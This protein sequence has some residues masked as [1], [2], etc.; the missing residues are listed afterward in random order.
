LVSL[1]DN[2]A[3]N[4][5]FMYEKFSLEQA[6]GLTGYTGTLPIEQ[7][8]HSGEVVIPASLGQMFRELQERRIAFFENPDADTEDLQ[9]YEDDTEYNEASGIVKDLQQRI[10][11]M[12]RRLRMPL[13]DGIF[14]NIESGG[15]EQ[16][17]E[18]MSKSLQRIYLEHVYNAMDHSEDDIVAW[19]DACAP[20]KS[21]NGIVVGVQD[22]G[23]GPDVELLANE[24]REVETR[25]GQLTFDAL[26]EYIEQRHLRSLCGED[27]I[28]HGVKGFQRGSGN[29][30]MLASPS[31]RCSHIVEPGGGCTAVAVH[32][33]NEFRPHVAA[34]VNPI[35]QAGTWQDCYR[36][37]FKG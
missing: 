20:D 31:V 21:T 34:G 35:Q 30:A 7:G 27:H 14:Y 32:S 19:F 6:Y 15:Y 25:A 28:G 4:Y 37:M 16:L 18:T 23:P 3:L 10:H 22:S 1:F 2:P 9:R 13:N 11:N 29:R 5:L 26:G 33:M 8:R 12:V 17:V 36:L 24:G